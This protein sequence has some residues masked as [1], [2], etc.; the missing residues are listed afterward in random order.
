MSQSPGNA[1]LRAVFDDVARL[2]WQ[3]HRPPSSAP[4]AGLEHGC[5]ICG[6]AFASRQQWGAHAQKLHGY[7]NMATQYAKG[8]VCRAC[9]S[10]YAN[11]ARLRCH[12]LSS[13]RCLQFLEQAGDPDPAL[14]LREGHVQAPVLRGWGQ[15]HLPAAQPETCAALRNGLAALQDASDQQ[16]FDEVSRHVA[17]L[18]VLHR[19]LSIWRDGLPSGALRDSASDV[20]LVLSPE[21]LCSGLA[22]R[23]PEDKDDEDAFLPLLLPTCLRCPAPAPSVL[24][25]GVPKDDW[26]SSWGFETCNVR[27]VALD[28]LAS[29]Y[30]QGVRC[31]GA[32]VDFPPPPHG[33]QPIR[34]PFPGPLRRLREHC[35]WANMLLKVFCCLYRTATLGR[36]ACLRLA[37]KPEHF[38]PITAWAVQSSLTQVGHQASSPP[39]FT[40]EFTLH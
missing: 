6:L 8:R 28:F 18:P 12:L 22:G 13:A 35:A 32:F 27:H 21:H 26:T 7:R 37:L 2:A 11:Q 1:R 39:C 14:N 40:L 20:L 15:A 33:S 34:Q 3:S 4:L 16:I 30:S 38:E 5:L 29:Q 19:T 31:Y 17:P 23:S 36:P 9:G 10:Q 24:A 25:F